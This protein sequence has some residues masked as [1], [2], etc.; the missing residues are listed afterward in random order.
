MPAELVRSDAARTDRTRETTEGEVAVAVDK[1]KQLGRAYV[2]VTESELEA[3]SVAG[4]LSRCVLERT[5]HVYTSQN[6][7][8]PWSD[9]ISA[10]LPLPR[11]KRQAPDPVFGDNGRWDTHPSLAVGPDGTVYL[12]FLETAGRSHCDVSTPTVPGSDRER[13][14]ELWELR[15]GAPAFV[16]VACHRPAGT[17]C[18]DT[19]TSEISEL[20]PDVNGTSSE[21]VDYPHLAVDPTADPLGQDPA[22]PD[23]IVITYVK[24]SLSQSRA[25]G[26]DRFVTLERAPGAAWQRVTPVGAPELVPL[27]PVSVGYPRKGAASTFTTPAFGPSG[28]L[29][30]A[31]APD[32]TGGH[33]GPI[34]GRYRLQGPGTWQLDPTV[35]NQGGPNASAPSLVGHQLIGS[36]FSSFSNV[37][38]TPALT[39]AAV[40]THETVFLAYATEADPDA[41]AFDVELSSALASDLTSWHSPVK[42]APK[43]QNWAPRLSVDPT[44]NVLDLIHYAADFVLI[45]NVEFNTVF[46]RFRANDLAPRTEPLVFDQN[47]P[48]S[49]HAPAD[50][51]TPAERAFVGDYLGLATYG[52]KAIVGFPELNET[53]AS[54]GE[55]NADLTL[56]YLEPLCDTSEGALTIAGRPDTVWECDCSCGGVPSVMSGCAPASATSAVD[57]CPHICIGTDCGAAQS[58]AS[59]RSCSAAGTGRAILPQACVF[60]FGPAA[61]S[62][63]SLFA[64]YYATALPD[65]SATFANGNDSAA[66]HLDGSVS[67]NVSSG[68]PVAGA[69]VE[70]ARLAL[71]PRSFHV[72]GSIGATV[73]DIRLEHLERLH[74]TFLDDRHFEIPAGSS[75]LVF[76]FVVDPDGPDFITGDPQTQ[77]LV[78]TNAAPLTGTLDVAL[79]ELSLDFAVGTDP[80]LVGHFHGALHPAPADSDG[81]GIPDPVD[82]CPTVFNPDQSDAPP[83]F[84]PVHDVAATACVA[85]DPVRL[86]PPAA[87]DACTPDQVTVEGSLISSNGVAYNPPIAI[88]DNQAVLPVGTTVIEWEAKDGNNHATHVR[89]TIRVDLTPPLQTVGGTYLADRAQVKLGNDAPA[90]VFDSGRILTQVGVGTHVGDISSVAPVIVA[91]RAF[92][93]G[94]RSEAGIGLGVGDTVSG[95]VVPNTQLVLPSPLELAGVTFPDPGA[96]DVS[97]MTGEISIP[98][99]SYRHVF[100]N[101]N[102]TLVL[103]AGRY[104]MNDLDVEWGGQIRIDDAFAPVSV[105]V[106]SSLTYRGPI[107]DASAALKPVFV[108]YLGTADVTLDTG[109]TGTF[110]APNAAVHAGNASTLR[111]DGLFSAKS[112]ELRPDVALVCNGSATALGELTPSGTSSCTD[113]VQNGAET[114]VDCGGYV[115]NPCGNGRRCVFGAD[116]AS[117]T[118]VTGTCQPSGSISAT[119][120]VT[121]NW[122]SGYCVTLR[123]HNGA[124]LP[125]TLWSV[126]LNTGASTISSSFNGA[127][128]KKAGVVT[129]TPGATFNQAVATGATDTSVGFCAN[130]TV[131]G[132]GVLP[133]VVAAGGTF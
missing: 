19:D 102:A 85:G 12:S 121:S 16:R 78:A 106:K 3:N 54:D 105:F 89:Q 100:V 101:G 10:N 64:D 66:T 20:D 5:I 60:D 122:A 49:T 59:A 73:R 69:R 39:V 41:E 96:T 35:P 103:S 132:S 67:L 31:S 46:R 32:H 29:Y 92:V 104:F 86:M 129:V 94:I 26:H 58:C 82:D 63:P 45:N 24:D 15:P 124:N 126:T 75:E 22:H 120:Q 130:R 88:Q 14:V 90:S 2:A 127:F 55:D 1:A 98:P 117:G 21:G 52:K 99:G 116:C 91:D 50:G 77:K 40:D 25:P 70:I 38:V 114:A 51:Q 6:G 61:G 93:G 72:G 111:F 113:G 36:I 80:G 107:V 11:T 57:A 23:R 48:R 74:G 8:D 71:A 9:S 128:T 84:A 27:D 119:L 112:F 43:I 4:N 65:S 87:N 7:G 83:T 109:F 62:Q 125:A 97:V 42:T 17:P 34:V 131:S 28:S 44:S 81:D 108:G 95:P 53:P 118:C 115:C 68:V 30:L 123:V 110:V 33:Q 79:Q 56:G 76:T 37:D 133:S 13:E 47:P 18:D